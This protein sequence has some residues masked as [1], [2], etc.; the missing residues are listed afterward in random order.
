MPCECVAYVDEVGVT[1]TTT[2][3]CQCS[4][5]KHRHS[6]I[7]VIAGGHFTPMQNPIPPP[8][9]PATSTRYVHV[10]LLYDNQYILMMNFCILF[11][12]L[13]QHIVGTHGYVRF[14]EW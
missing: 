2:S 14:D 4:H 7:G 13:L 3:Y 5:E 10:V 11:P 8:M 6:V 12:F 1:G 9:T